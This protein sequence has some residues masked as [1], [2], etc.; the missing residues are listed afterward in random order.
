M[1]LKQ[2][3]S[4]SEGTFSVVEKVQTVERL[5]PEKSSE[6][7]K[8]IHFLPRELI[9]EMNDFTC[10]NSLIVFASC[11]GGKEPCHKCCEQCL[12]AHVIKK[13]KEKDMG[14]NV[15]SV[16]NEIFLCEA[17]HDGHYIDSDVLMKN[18]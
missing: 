18:S 11:V 12:K 10:R 2:K 5:F 9:D 14:K 16:L 13:C 17:G 3:I 1:V 4:A 15:V 6:T 7:R 8:K